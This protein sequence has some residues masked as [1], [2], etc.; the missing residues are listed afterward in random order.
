MQPKVKNVKNK[1]NSTFGYLQKDNDIKP[2]E[3]M[4]L[5]KLFDHGRT[6]LI[7]MPALMFHLEM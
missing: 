5:Y 4:S 6:V 2:T 3:L 1:Q 7:L